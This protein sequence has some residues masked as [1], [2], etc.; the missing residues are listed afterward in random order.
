MEKEKDMDTP[1]LSLPSRTEALILSLLQNNK[2]MYGLEIIEASGNKLKRGTIYVTLH[3]M[4]NKGFVES[5]EESRSPSE[6]GIP[7][8]LYKITGLGERAIAAYEG[9]MNIFGLHEAYI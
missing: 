8:R 2:E 7:R 1:E 4:E 5:R 3:R 6:G 9:A